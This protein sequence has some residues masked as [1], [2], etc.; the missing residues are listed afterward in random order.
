M[1]AVALACAPENWDTG[2][3]GAADVVAA[4]LRA[5]GCGDVFACPP[6]A[7]LCAEPVV[8]ACGGWERESRQVDGGERGIR[9]VEVL[10][11]REDPRAAEAVACALECGVRTAGWD[12]L[13]AGWHMRVVAADTE[14]PTPRGRDGS[15]R[16]VWGFTVRLT[17]ARDFDE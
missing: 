15:G 8:V 3:G 1:G 10:A 13:G 17:I 14:A 6:S 12:G 16:W 7:R 4:L 5:L 11:C 2:G 9:E